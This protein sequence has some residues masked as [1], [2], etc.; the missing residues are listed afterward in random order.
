MKTNF[1]VGHRISIYHLIAFWLDFFW[2]CSSA[3]RIM[4][5]S[6]PKDGLQCFKKHYRNNMKTVAKLNFLF[7]LKFRRWY[8]GD[9]V[10]DYSECK[11]Q[12]RQRVSWKSLWIAWLCFTVFVVV[13]VAFLMLIQCKSLI[14]F[15]WSRNAWSSSQT[16]FS[17]WWSLG[18]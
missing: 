16:I 17:H 12:H 15:L 4:L 13:V 14:V 11:L 1:F 8:W 10:L 9:A 7:L 2:D 5:Y 18:T 3:Q 6:V